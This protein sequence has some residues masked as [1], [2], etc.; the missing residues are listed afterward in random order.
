MLVRARKVGYV[1]CYS[2]TPRTQLELH[3]SSMQRL[4]IS[5][6]SNKE[7]YRLSDGTNNNNTTIQELQQHQCKNSHGCSRWSL[8]SSV[9]VHAKVKG[10]LRSKTKRKIR[11]ETET[12]YRAYRGNVSMCVILADCFVK[13][14]ILISGF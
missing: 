3:D 9:V 11:E 12:T 14:Q 8:P 10:L 1:P 6:G 2:L 13:M 4:L 7:K 5:H